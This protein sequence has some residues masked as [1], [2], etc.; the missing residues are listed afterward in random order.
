M[1]LSAE[2]ARLRDAAADRLYTAF[3]TYGARADYNQ[4]VADA[5]T[6]L[7]DARHSVDDVS[8]GPWLERVGIATTNPNAL[9]IA[10]PS[11]V[12]PS[13]GLMVA[14]VGSLIGFGGL[15]LY[16]LYSAFRGATRRSRRRRR[17]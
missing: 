14:A 4:A 7:I 11:P 16:G 9:L 10:G 8:L 17:R 1:A 13:T 2:N 15:F 3:E 5:M 6:E 12:A